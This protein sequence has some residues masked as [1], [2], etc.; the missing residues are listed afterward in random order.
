MATEFTYSIANDFPNQTIDASVLTAEI[1][2]SSIGPVLEGITIDGD[3]VVITFDDDLSTG[4]ETTL[5]GIVAAHQGDPFVEDIQKLFSEGVQTETGTTFVEAASLDSGL[6]AAGEYLIT[7]YSEISVETG[8]NTSGVIARVLWNG[9]ER[10][11]SAGNL[12]FYQSFGGSVI[13]DVN[14]LAAP[15]LSVEFRRVGTA[16]T[17]RIRRIR[18]SIAPLM[19]ES[20]EEE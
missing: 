12:S 19:N 9:T 7:W 1:N 10:A 2:A 3:D 16:N 14:A 8:D 20:S 17:A 4:E 15:S 13:V 6:L 5:D 11:E 18:L